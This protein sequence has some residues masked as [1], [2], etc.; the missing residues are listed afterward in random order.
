MALPPVLTFSGERHFAAALADYI[1]SHYHDEKAPQRLATLRV[2]LPNR[3]AITQLQQALFTASGH[4]P[5]LLPALYSIG[6]LQPH[7][8]LSPEAFSSIEVFGG[9][10]RQAWVSELMHGLMQRNIFAAFAS[11]ERSFLNATRYAE[12]FL[13]LRDDCLRAEVSAEALER[14][15]P[16]E[17]AAHW[18]EMLRAFRAVNQALDSYLKAEHRIEPVTYQHRLARLIANTWQESPPAYPLIA[19]GSTASTL[20]TALLLHRIRQLPAGQVILPGL[21]M[22]MSEAAWREVHVTHPQY[23]IKQWLE[24]GGLTRQEVSCI[25]VGETERDAHISR[26][27]LP[28]AAMDAANIARISC[29]PHIN[30][31]VCADDVCEVELTAL[32][33]RQSLEERAASIHVVSEDDAFITRL[34]ALLGRWEVSLNRAAG[35]P[36]LHHP[37]YRMVIMTAELAFLPYQSDRLLAV[38]RNP[39]SFPELRAEALS[40]A[41]WLD[42]DILRG[43]HAYENIGDIAALCQRKGKGTLLEGMLHP[44]LQPEAMLSDYF[45]IHQRILQYVAG[46]DSEA[47][48]LLE[49]FGEF[50]TFLTRQPLLNAHEYLAL[51]IQHFARLRIALPV[52]DNAVVSVMGAL[53]MRLHQADI[54][55]IPQMNKGIWPRFISPEPWLNQAMRR[56]LGLNFAEHQGALAAHDLCMLLKAPKILLLRA[57]KASDLPTQPSR[58]F[59]RLQ[60]VC[61]LSPRPQLEAWRELQR[62]SLPLPASNAMPTPPVQLRMQRLSATAVETLLRNP[63]E[64]YVSHICRL[65]ERYPLDAPFSAADLGSVLHKVMEQASVYYTPSELQPYFDRLAILLSKAL[66]GYVAPAQAQFYT[67]RLQR[68][69]HGVIET[70]SVRTPV[71]AEMEAEIAYEAPWVTTAGTV[72]VSAKIDRIE[73]RRDQTIVLIDHKTGKPPS[74]R[75][76]SERDRCQLVIA[77]WLMHTLENTPYES[78]ILEYWQLKGAE[79]LENLAQRVDTGSRGATLDW[80]AVLDRIASVL[81]Y[82]CFDENA[83]FNWNHAVTPY[84]NAMDHLA[85]IRK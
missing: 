7:E 75:D 47:S 44:A 11:E 46:N 65:R 15:V 8:W 53:E 51:L 32:T 12:S 48:A 56:Q 43:W 80:S 6:D 36:A 17:Y 34:A 70:E 31:H 2:L 60:W 45:T 35:L 78:M 42:K 84:G 5:L 27:M 19:A 38:L 41:E 72:T 21:D 61:P 37:A 58:F 77:G 74:F 79:V 22:F 33:I 54:V 71:I 1:L 81:A 10:A 50:S 39:Q 28:A 82:Y 20:P 26:I 4:K 9:V 83:S 13:N 63:F 16:T 73:R 85:R 64:I 59:E 29:L 25:Q 18:S 23:H 52:P 57:R 68:I 55:I 66:R 14:V 24:A 76:V 62:L 3:R 67:R 40:L 49:G 69:L 30:L